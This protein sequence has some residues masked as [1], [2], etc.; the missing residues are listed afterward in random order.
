[1]PRSPRPTTSADLRALRE[2]A[3]AG[4]ILLDFDGSLAEIVDRP[5]LARPAAGV[6]EALVPLTRR[7]RLVAVITGRRAAEVSPLLDVPNVRLLGLYGFEDDGP[8]LPAALLP[9][10]EAAAAVVP[11]AWVEDKD[12]SIAVHYRGSPDPA[13]AR[14]TLAAALR[15][16]ATDGGL[17]LV[18]GKM[19]VELVPADRPMK[20]GAVERL[21]GEH[22]LGAVLYAGDDHADVDA[23]AALDRL[24]DR[25]MVTIKVAV[26]GPETPAP[27][28]EEAD[29]IVEGPGG[30][31]DLLGQLA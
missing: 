31:V 9:T 21:A 12:A 2:R 17:E 27:L 24:A 23:F 11:E 20:G 3:G 13:R 15:A 7:Y 4:G 14:A 10:V 16:V 22:G 1:M 25:G 8:R 29:L 26:R 5:E 30:L 28:L 19:V 18:E 6:R